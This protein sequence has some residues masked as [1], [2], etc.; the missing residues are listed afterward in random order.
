MAPRRFLTE[1]TYNELVSA[2]KCAQAG[3]ASG[4]TDHSALNCQWPCSAG[5]PCEVATPSGVNTPMSDVV[6]TPVSDAD[7]V[8]EVLTSVSA[9]AA[10]PEVAG[11]PDKGV[12]SELQRLRREN[13]ALAAENAVLRDTQT[14]TSV[15]GSSRLTLP[16]GALHSSSTCEHNCSS[17]V[18]SPSLR[19]GPPLRY[20]VCSPMGTTA[21]RNFEFGFEDAA[22]AAE[23]QRSY[24]KAATLPKELMA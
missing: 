23:L 16:C 7:V 1:R 19:L 21:D 20:I 4:S 15:P 8:S 24:R 22:G 10:A 13:M 5:V 6:Q 17:G 11:R 2:A 18:S 9:L 14:K 12:L 3:Q